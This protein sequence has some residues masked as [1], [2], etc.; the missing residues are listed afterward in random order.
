MAVGVSDLNTL[1]V[2]TQVLTV[3]EV[4]PYPY[5]D[6][7]TLQGDAALLKLTPVSAPAPA[8]TIPLA[9][10]AQSSLYAA[11]Q[12]VT[13]MGWG[14]TS[15]AATT[16]PNVLQSGAV[17][18]Q[19]NAAC[20]AGSFG[21]PFYPA[22]DMCASVPGFIPST[23][24][25]DSGGPLVENTPAGPVEIGVVSYGFG[26]CL[27]SAGF[28]TRASSIQSWVASVVAG[29]PAPPRYTPPFA[30]PT[31]SA[32]LSEDGVVG[33]LAVSP[34]PATLATGLT[35]VLTNSAGTV[36]ATQTLAPLATTVSFPHL[37]PGTYAIGVSANYSDGTS[38]PASSA[39]VTLAPPLNA[40]K[41]AVTGKHIVGSTLTCHTGTWAWP[42]QSTL[43]LTWLRNGVT[44]GGTASTHRLVGA[45]AGKSISCRVVLT[46]STGSQAAASSGT[47]VAHA[48]LGVMSAP[49]ITGN[50]ALGSKLVCH[51]GT[52]S[53]T[54]ALKLG[55]RW[56]RK[57]KPLAGRAAHRTVVAADAGRRLTCRVTASA[58]GQ[59]ASA[60]TRPVLVPV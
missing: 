15:P 13:A 28:Y 54:G 47:V 51:P 45:D 37:Q 29:A 18:I 56:L 43:A 6:P 31:V 9:T 7:A 23:C 60:A 27:Q 58:P 1:D 16:G 30:A 14:L 17:T 36:V 48:K 57:G 25:G 52:W 22:Y 40:T 19:S 53:H 11:G 21:Q 42:G 35:A 3:S 59:T 39:G 10:P 4:D 12:P 8:A 24:H 2:P 26:S 46:A 55:Y 5:Y 38:D 32:V 49:R 44:T 50:G 34:D 20:A 33:T 41:P